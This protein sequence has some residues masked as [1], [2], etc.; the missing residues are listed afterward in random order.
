MTRE[1]MIEMV[2]EAIEDYG[3]RARTWEGGEHMRVYIT[4][5]LSRGR[6]Q[7]IGFIAVTE[8]GKRVYHLSRVSAGT[9]EHVE[10][11]FERE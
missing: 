6:R 4:R 11:Y 5:T 9:R 3:M 2:A 10:R 1:E 7:D 8:D